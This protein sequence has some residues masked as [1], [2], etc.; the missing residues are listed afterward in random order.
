MY[1]VLANKQREG[2]ERGGMTKIEASAFVPE[3]EKESQLRQPAQVREKW[4]RVE[5]GVFT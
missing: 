5:E 3:N 4:G 2:R 1:P